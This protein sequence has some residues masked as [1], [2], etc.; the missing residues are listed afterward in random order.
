MR[1]CAPL[2]HEH[3]FSA[4]ATSGKHRLIHS[5]LSS[6]FLTQAAQGIAK[7][8]TTATS[9][10]AEL[11]NV[12]MVVEAVLERMDLKQKVFKQL[13]EACGPNTILCTNTSTLDVDA[14]ANATSR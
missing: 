12:D 8:L 1:R 14:I 5:A 2:L 7:Q 10:G 13:D 4:A 6:A 11:A 3:T 9:I